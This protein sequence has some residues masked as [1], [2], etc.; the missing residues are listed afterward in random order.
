MI[1]WTEFFVASDRSNEGNVLPANH[2][3]LNVFEE[4]KVYFSISDHQF[5]KCC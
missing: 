3:L 1:G 2:D 4:L 5:D